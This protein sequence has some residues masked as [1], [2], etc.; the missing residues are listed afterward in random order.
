MNDDLTPDERWL[1]EALSSISHRYHDGAT[2]NPR[3][4]SSRRRIGTMVL[5]G[6]V[7]AAIVSAA[8][9]LPGL[10]SQGGRGFVTPPRPP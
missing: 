2:F 6:I 5:A 4:P 9:L 1:A 7:T 8:I 10:D 3:P